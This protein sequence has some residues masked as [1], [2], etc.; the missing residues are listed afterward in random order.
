MIV[1]KY[2]LGVEDGRGP[3]KSMF[4]LST[5][6]VL[7]RFDE[8]AHWRSMESRLQFSTHPTRRTY[9]LYFISGIRQVL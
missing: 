6:C 3:L 9:F 1:I 5:G 2:L 8:R 7:C 4:N